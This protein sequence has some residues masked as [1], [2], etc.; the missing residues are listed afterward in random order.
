MSKFGIFK[1]IDEYF[2]KY[3]YGGCEWFWLDW[4]RSTLGSTEDFKARY[5]QHKA[6]FNKR[7][8]LHTTLS[9]YVRKLKDNNIPYEIRW[10]IKARGHT[11]SS[12]GQ[13]CDLCLTEKLVILTEDQ[14]TMLNKSRRK[15]MLV[16][17]KNSSIDTG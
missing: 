14:N 5:Y 8:A 11:F 1:E 4:L 17:Q 10:S 3:L 9:S 2:W 7:P 16:S 6:S 13:A 15:H 12:G